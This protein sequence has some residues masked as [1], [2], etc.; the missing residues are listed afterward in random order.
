MKNKIVLAVLLLVCLVTFGFQ[1]R[2]TQRWEYKVE[3]HGT[4]SE[5]KLNELG[6]EGWELVSTEISIKNGDSNVTSFYFK[7]QKP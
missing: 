1:V 3:Y 7:R 4:I 2:P 5:K 6:A